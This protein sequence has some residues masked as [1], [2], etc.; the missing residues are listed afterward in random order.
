MNSRVIALVS[1][2]LFLLVI[3]LGW[4]QE[5][6]VC[7]TGET[8]VISDEQ[9]SYELINFFHKS[10]DVLTCNDLLNLTSLSITS[11]QPYGTVKTLE[12][13][14][15]AV[16]LEEINLPFPAAYPHPYAAH[17]VN[18]LTPLAGL[19]HLKSIA[20]KTLGIEDLSPL[21]NLANL[22]SLSLMDNFINDL[23]PLSHLSNLKTLQL[24]GNPIEDISFLKN[25]TGLETLWL[26]ET[27]LTQH[28][29]HPKPNLDD[30]DTSIL[31]NFKALKSLDVSGNALTNLGFLS[32]LTHL[33]LLRLDNNY[34][35]DLAPLEQNPGIGAGDVIDLSGNCLDLSPASETSRIIAELA[36]RG[37]AITVEPQ[38]PADECSK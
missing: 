12:G 4:T 29:Q 22:E 20:M 11:L 14:Q 31:T 16:N 24:S 34:L 18:D 21:S 15:F 2:G 8:V 1:L 35:R 19:I 37:V 38:R 32:D 30:R 28:Y 7:E 27:A 17:S 3:S 36:A 5:E 33:T 6:I 13:L 23:S 9:L 26:G 10:K 25:L